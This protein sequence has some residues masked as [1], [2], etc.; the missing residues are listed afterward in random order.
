LRCPSGAVGIKDFA[1][2]DLFLHVSAFCG[3]SRYMMVRPSLVRVD[4]RLEFVIITSRLKKVLGSNIF[5]GAK[6]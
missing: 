4:R 5:V 1:Q 3:A 2:F 6:I